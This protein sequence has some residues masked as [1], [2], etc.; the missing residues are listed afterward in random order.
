[1]DRQLF[2]GLA[3]LLSSVSA[4]PNVVYAQSAIEHH[5]WQD[6]R[7]FQAFSHT[8]TA[9]TGSIGLSGNP[10]FA[11]K[12]SKM[13]LTFGNGKAVQLIQV[14]AAWRKFSLVTDEKVTAEIFRMDHDP[15]KLEN[16]N[17]LCGGKQ[18]KTPIYIV[19][20]EGS[21]LGGTPLLETAVF[22]SRKIPNDRD[23]A[24]LCGTFNYSIN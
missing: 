17:S 19:F 11:T 12:G 16:G 21:I 18:S 15:G 10:N 9:I 14:G 2:V 20:F 6:K 5:V 22:Q 13:I 3:A 24:G 23:S 7:I 8:S 4:S 1:M